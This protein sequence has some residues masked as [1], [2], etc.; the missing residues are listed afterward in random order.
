VTYQVL[1]PI[2]ACNHCCDAT[3]LSLGDVGS[4]RRSAAAQREPQT[5]LQRR[6]TCCQRMS[7]A[8]RGLASKQRGGVSL[9]GTSGC[10][11]V[12]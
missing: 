2:I 5:S 7:E 12:V 4:P 6:S 9:Q 8:E 3:G 11:E 1:A 10:A